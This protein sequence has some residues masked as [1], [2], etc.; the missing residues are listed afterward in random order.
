MSA[1]IPTLFYA[2]LI[3][4]L[5]WLDRDVKARTSFALW[6]P[7]IWLSLAGSRSASEWLQFAPPGAASE[8]LL[9][10]DP[11]NRL[12]Y[13]VLVALGLIV[14]L[15]RAPKAMRLLQANG[16]VVA[17]LFYCL[18]S[19]M[20]AQYPD[21]GFKRWVKAA[22]D[23]VMVLIVVSER[24]PAV[25]IRR[26]LVRTGFILIPLSVLMIK[27]YPDLARYYD[28]WEW[29][30]YYSGV[31]TNKN[32]LGLICMLFGIASVWQALEAVFGPRV[33]G[34][35]RRFIAHGVML[36]MVLWLFSLARSMTAFACFTLGA[37]LL[38]LLVFVRQAEGGD[39]PPGNRLV[40]HGLVAVLIAV[41]S[42]VVFI[43]IEAILTMMGKDPTLT[44]RTLIWDLLLSKVTN[45]W[46][47]TGFENF[48]LGPRLDE[49]WRVYTWAP[50]QAH[51]G[52][53]EIYLNLG[54][55]GLGL[56]AVTL[57]V[58]YQAAM[59]ALR[60][61]P[62]IGSLM[63]TYFVVGIV[64]N[65]TEAG[66]FRI[67][68]PVWFVLLLAITRVP[69]LYRLKKSRPASRR[70]PGHVAPRGLRPYGKMRQRPLAA[71]R[72]A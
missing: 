1:S 4:A 26:L 3:L 67:S 38:L 6:L 68:A 72:N 15:F 19:L 69:E 32:A 49:I 8:A 64:Y 42:A 7:I 55:V 51:N 2:A 28:R 17:F 46:L 62:A 25:A 22:G 56:L 31:T 43:G 54:L 18:L 35:L 65:F 24:D 16:A 71:S 33:P 11:I 14:L 52:Y 39:A 53:L 36:V 27:Y 60:R 59:T 29:S 13:G 40:V 21:V 20:W 12:V 23:L 57:L 30:T 63:L 50:N 9:E 58:G 48:W 5:F 47:G 61:A 45:V 10:G 37:V 41:P 70:E 34:R 44:D 66:F